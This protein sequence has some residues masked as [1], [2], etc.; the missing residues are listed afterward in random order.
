VQ[1]PGRFFNQSTKGAG[2]SQTFTIKRGDTSPSLR[3]ELADTEINL[4]G[5][6]VIFNMKRLYNGAVV[7]DRAS[8]DVVTGAAI[9][10]L[11]YSWRAEDTAVPG[12][13]RAEFE[14]TFADLSVETFPN[15]EYIVVNILQDLG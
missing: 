10:T 13:Y 1:T 12:I 4:T 2:M 6:S 14:I 3:W 9:P 11:G 15:G 8:A 5:A 7:V